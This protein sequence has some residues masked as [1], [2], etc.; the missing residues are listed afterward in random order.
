MT[1]IHPGLAKLREPFA[2]HQIGRKPKGGVQLEFVGHAALTDRL[3]EVDPHWSWE[4]FAVGEDGLPKFDQHGGLWMWLTIC[5]VRRLG[6]GDADG[7]K[8]AVAVK[9]AIGDGLRNGGMRFGAALDLWHKGDLHDMAAES[10]PSAPASKPAAAKPAAAKPKPD[11]AEASD[12][13][14]QIVARAKDAL[15]SPP[16][17]TK[18]VAEAGGGDSLQ[19]EKDPVVLR[20]V[21]A[22]IPPF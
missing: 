5:G 14:A 4:P 1:E 16:A 3:L 18:L 6:Y 7:K 10:A 17:V 8:G 20:A 2:P 19:G 12:L 11:N 21:L 22:L 15:L 9:E 13:R